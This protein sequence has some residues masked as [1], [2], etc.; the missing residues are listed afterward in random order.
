MPKSA[1]RY[2][3]L[4]GSSHHTGGAAFTIEDDDTRHDGDE[5][6]RIEMPSP[7]SDND[8]VSPAGPA[9]TVT[10]FAVV[11][12]W[13][14][15]SWEFAKFWISAL[16]SSVTFGWIVPLLEVGNSRRLEPSDL[17]PLET[18]DSAEGCYRAFMEQWHARKKR[19]HSLAMSFF[20]AFGMPFA[21]AGGI[22][23]LH[24]TLMFVGPQVL[25]RLIIFMR[26]PSE[27][28]ST[29][30]FYV[31]VLFVSQLLMSVF[32]RQY[33][34]WCFRVGMRLRSAIV[35]SV[36][37]K[38][39]SISTGAFA[40]KS[41]GEIQ[42]LMAVDSTRLQDLT[43]YLHAVWYSLYQIALALYLLWAEVGA[44]SLA[45]ICVILLTIP[46]TG[47]V[48]TMLKDI[49]QKV[50]SVRDERIKMSNEVLSGTKVIKLQ[51]WE[52]EFESRINALR[53]RELTLYRQYV[54]TQALSGTLFTVIPLLVAIS[55][56]SAYVFTGNKLNVQTALTSLALFDLLRFPLF[57]L[58]NTINSIVE[59]QVSVG[60]IQSFL[61]EN[62]RAPV[63]SRG[64]RAPGLR[65]DKVTCVWDGVGRLVPAPASAA[66][67][68]TTW[69][70]VKA[71]CQR[72]LHV[73][74]CIDAPQ[75]GADEEAQNPTNPLHGQAGHTGKK[76]SMPP[77]RLIC[78]NRANSDGLG[79]SNCARGALGPGPAATG[80]GGHWERLESAA[81]DDLLMH[82]LAK[83]NEVRIAS[84]EREVARLRGIQH[85]QD[86]PDPDGDNQEPG[87]EVAPIVGSGS[88]S[89]SSS[90]SRRSSN[91]IGGSGI[92]GVRLL[93]LSRL[94]LEVRPGE[95]MAIV[96]PVGSGKSSVI[97]SV[98]G[99]LR[100]F[101]GD[102]ACR[103]SVAFV[104]QR[105]FIFNATVKNNILNLRGFDADRYASVCE[106]CALVPDFA[107]LPAGDE[108]E[109]GERGINLSGGQKAR[110]A[111]A[112]AVYADAD[113]YLL[114]DV[115]SAV[116]SHTAVHLLERVVLRLQQQGKAVLLAT[117]ALQVLPACSR[118]VVLEGGRVAAEGTFEQLRRGDPGVFSD[119]MAAYSASMARDEAV[120]NEAD[121]S[122]PT[123][124]AVTPGAE[125]ETQAPLAARDKKDKQVA[126]RV[127]A[128]A[129]TK[130]SAATGRLVEAEDR[131]IGHVSRDVYLIW[132]RA[133]GGG[134]GLGV[135][136]T[137]LV[138]FLACE[139]ANVGS[140]VWLGF[141]SAHHAEYSTGFFLGVYCLLCLAIALCMAAR[142][143]F[144]RLSSW[145]AG[146]T[147]FRQ[148]L[149]S[150]LYAPMEFFDT[151]PL[152]MIYLPHLAL[153]V[154]IY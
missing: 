87:G 38:T 145:R 137:L 22:K 19:T 107:V 58:P 10:K 4:E 72:C 51:A 148:F 133:A 48:S 140:S 47:K 90:S 126:S 70:R 23:L 154:L 74:G 17:F 37:A 94:S 136:A 40:R 73:I 98:L 24:D 42:N 53:D 112:R 116:D 69:G 101:F 128:D 20:S 33:F 115:L 8:D 95:L 103:G 28:L 50:V 14:L 149:G 150:V 34:F 18:K 106:A 129:N 114:D 123:H 147:L 93:A 102:V 55:T 30:L 49:Q 132:L 59:A 43:P 29:G 96:G 105:P 52:R 77:S 15:S 138:L 99:D 65:M 89:S 100:L 3:A 26:T 13:R 91:D 45:A 127:A 139:A 56:F 62:E 144:T 131:E 54:L 153:H 64:L 36:F 108:T 16:W 67:D 110:V 130:A 135:G 118:V 75:D 151:T 27:A 124:A 9:D 7:W 32:L 113:V 12:P 46:L 21:A 84:L 79:G 86:A 76:T 121:A 142:E 39:L 104:G 111:L 71:A 122:A 146:Q 80:H 57:M 6:T 83:A 66:R 152:G 97:L 81:Y 1:D 117:N 68:D 31:A 60:R 41:T 119:M 143:I 35:T 78:T 82:E 92:G 141:W 25:K 109:I 88:S 44:A 63:P 125:D 61:L 2:K 5:S 85:G 120:G 134:S 11:D